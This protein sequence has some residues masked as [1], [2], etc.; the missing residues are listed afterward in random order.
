MNAV[1]AARD[2]SQLT[3]AHAVPFAVFMG[4][5]L[6]LPLLQALIGWD[7]PDAPWWR[8]DPAHLV[9]PAQTLVCLAL[10]IHYRRSYTF[11]WSWKWFLPAV[12]FG[13]AGIGLW[14]LPTTLYDHWGL[15]GT[16]DGLLGFFGVEARTKGFDPGIFSDPAAFWTVL[17]LRFLRAVVVVAF[18]EEIFWR[19]LVMRLACDWQGDFWKQPFGRRDWRSYAVVTGLFILAHSPPDRVGAL[20]YG[21]LTWCLC[22]WSRSLGACVLMHAVANLLMGLYIMAYGKYGLW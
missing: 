19:G 12:A 22:V 14:L 20:A 18:V 17:I 2:T 11:D 21:T 5:L 9:Y 6:V 4:F 1:P 15:T 8:R 3:R 7:H 13:A 16:P 10:L